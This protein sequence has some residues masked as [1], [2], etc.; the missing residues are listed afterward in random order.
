MRR[1]GLILAALLTA[2]PGFAQAPTISNGDGGVSA[3]YAAPG[4]IPRRPGRL[5]RQE[6]LEGAAALAAAA[7]SIRIL[8]SSTDGLDGKSAITVSGALF[9][10]KG[11]APRGGW[12][13]MAWA[14]GT[15]GVADVCAPSWAGRSARDV[16]YLGHWLSQGYAV[17]ASDYQGL[18]VTGGHPYL[19][20]R[21]AAYSI[22]DSVRA[23]Q[24]GGFGISKKVVLIGQSQGG[25][26]AYAAAGYAPVYARELDV[27]GTVAT[28]V[29]YY[30]EEGKA[31]IA[32]SR[33]RDV[34][35]ATLSYTVLRMFTARQTDP[36]FSFEQTFSDSGLALARTATSAC[37]GPMNQQITGQG[38]TFNKV[39]KQDPTASVERL[40]DIMG[41]RTLKP[42][43]PVFVGTGGKDR[44][45]P[46]GAQLALVKDSCAAGAVVEAR[47]YP[48]LDHSG[49][50]NGSV[51]DSTPF[52]RK[53]FAGEKIAGNCPT[54]R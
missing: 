13:L 50:V 36:R 12:P 30:S 26:A 15:V 25:G 23:V 52:V 46:P 3:F 42:R 22:L 41:Y 33:P 10:P 27:R 11:E 53:A 31:A 17:V 29:P 19:A 44:D 24:G 38:L 51:P 37:L 40:Y 32:A 34:V 8:Y 2:G 5:I 7:R 18:G 45:V 16:T 6:L 39:F 9:L 47:L 1:Q 20:S 43:G 48:D 28:G 4:A 14:H 21:P 49:T 54:S 35:D